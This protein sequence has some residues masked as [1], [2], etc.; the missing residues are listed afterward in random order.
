MRKILNFPLFL[1]ILTIIV[2]AS[3]NK[4]DQSEID[5]SKIKDYLAAHDI[6]AIKDN[7]GLYYIITKEGNGVSPTLN[8]TVEVNYK[9]YLTNGTVFDETVNT[10]VEFALYRLITGWQIG[11]PLL[12]E[13]GKGTFFTPSDLGYGARATGSIPAN[14]VLIFEIELVNV[15]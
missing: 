15:K 9:G 11:I 6:D 5:D 1:A 13:G 12:S 8:S 7:S 10:S 4:D 3:C 2:A 14:S